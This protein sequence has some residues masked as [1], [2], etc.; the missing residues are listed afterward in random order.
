MARTYESIRG[1][2]I[3]T[4]A[5]LATHTAVMADDQ[6]A[7]NTDTGEL[8]LGSGTIASKAVAE[9]ATVVAADKIAI[10]DS[11]DGRKKYALASAL[12]TFTTT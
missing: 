4:T 7:Y 2:T 12:K 3:G 6:A 5:E 8:F 11:V 1:I 10:I 9:K